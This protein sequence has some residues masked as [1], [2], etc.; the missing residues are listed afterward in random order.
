MTPAPNREPGLPIQPVR[1]LGM[2]LAGA[3][4]VGAG[5]TGPVRP[6]GGRYSHFPVLR[7]SESRA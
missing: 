5:C 3:P 6:A 7:G 1:G 2:G 4:K